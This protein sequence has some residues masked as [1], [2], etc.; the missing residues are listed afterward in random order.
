M[1]KENKNDLEENLFNRIIEL[2]FNKVSLITNI[3]ELR[4]KLNEKLNEARKLILN[5]KIDEAEDIIENIGY[6]VDYNKRDIDEKIERVK[7]IRKWINEIRE[8][9]GKLKS[10]DN[11]K[12]SQVI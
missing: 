12:L 3:D 1:K 10:K 11:K 9:I 2:H 8:D 5:G 7:E 6:I 4:D